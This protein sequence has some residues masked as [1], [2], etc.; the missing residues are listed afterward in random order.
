MKTPAHPAN[1]RRT[2]LGTEKIRRQRDDRLNFEKYYATEPKTNEDV[3][4]EIMERINSIRH[5]SLPPDGFQLTLE[6]RG[7][8]YQLKTRNSIFTLLIGW[9]DQSAQWY[10]IENVAAY[11][12]GIQQGLR[13]VPEPPEPKGFFDRL[14]NL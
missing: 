13:M 6:K 11:L 14:F 3:T 5:P 2:E 10:P 4:L 7:H 8:R 9:N 1:H 12:F